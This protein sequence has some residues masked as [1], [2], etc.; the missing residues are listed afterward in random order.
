MAGQPQYLPAVPVSLG[1][2]VPPA[3]GEVGDFRQGSEASRAVVSRYLV[4]TAL[5]QSVNRGMWLGGILLLVLAAVLWAVGWHLLAVLPAL[6]AIAV[7][8]VRLAVRAVLSRLLL[9]GLAPGNRAVVNRLVRE[10][11]KDVLR[12]L[13]RLGLPGHDLTLPL[14]GLRLVRPTRRG[15]TMTRLRQ[16]DLDRVVPAAR[17]DELHLMLRALGG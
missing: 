3:G 12:E 10:T 2:D 4:G 11:R 7:L 1:K 16:F 15:Q 8:V 5:A 14:L 17:V 6:V 9:S 13:R